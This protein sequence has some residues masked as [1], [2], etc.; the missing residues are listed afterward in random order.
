MDRDQTWV[1]TLPH[2]GLNAVDV[3][4]LLCQL[5]VRWNQDDLKGANEVWLVHR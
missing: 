1:E 3:L 2:I 5:T 4:H